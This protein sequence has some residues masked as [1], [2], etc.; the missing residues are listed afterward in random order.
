M[1]IID[2]FKQGNTSSG[3]S[4]LGNVALAVIKGI[5]AVISG[6][7]SMFATTMH[8]A[9]DATNQGFVFFGSAL[10]EKEPTKRF[11]AG[12]G[13]VI[14]LFVLVAVAIVTV[15]A[16]ETIITGWEGI[17]HPEA[18]TNFWMNVIILTISVAIDGSVLIKAMNEVVK[19]S[20]SSASGFQV[21]PEAF[22]NIRYAAP[23]TRLVFYEDI[24]ATFGA[25]LALVF[26]VLSDITGMYMLDG[27][28]SVLIGLLLIG[29]VL[30]IGYDN[31]IGLIGV[32][33][34]KKVD[35]RITKIVMDQEY[36][37]D[38]KAMR[39]LQEGKD[40]HVE[41]YVEL[42]KGLSL[43]K[44]DDVKRQIREAVLD[45]PDIDDVTLGVIEADE[46]Q[47]IKIEDK[48]QPE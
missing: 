35:E 24:V 26:V 19:E 11:P 1:S 30:K 4:A 15:M 44:A 32:A 36:V 37:E 10:A 45:D 29:I 9:A 22:K 46:K 20:H 14:N 16:Y 39:I 13:R 41:G 18:S 5:G 34:P 43:D 23:P 2:F 6:S 47:N 12:F 31:T 8:S 28:G 48:P 3:I 42:K 27:V 25:F 33:A 38:I 40:Y 7:G 21:L 17:Q